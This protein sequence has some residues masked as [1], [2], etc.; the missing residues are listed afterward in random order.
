MVIGKLDFS[1]LNSGDAWLALITFLYVD[2]L[3]AT[4][5]LFSMASFI[6]LQMGGGFVQPDKSWDRSLYAFCSDGFAVVISGLFGSSSATAYIESASGIREGGRTGITGLTICGFFIISL[7]FN[8]IFASIPPY[9][10]GPALITVGSMMIANIV[11]IR[12]DMVTESVPAFLT[13]AVMPLTYSIAY[14]FLA[15]AV[16]YIIFAA[17]GWGIDFLTTHGMPFLGPSEV[18]LAKAEM[19]EVDNLHDPASAATAPRPSSRKS[20]R[21]RA[22]RSIRTRPLAPMTRLMQ[23]V[24]TRSKL[25]PQTPRRR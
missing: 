2:F 13:I 9:A 5:T 11:K 3:D 25:P 8:P 24:P 15:G 10:V 23:A 21:R 16:S 6:D 4:G 7:F 22:R 17:L 19:L 12:W 20:R 14:G 18:M 1:G